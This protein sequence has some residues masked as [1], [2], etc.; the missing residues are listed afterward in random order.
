MCHLHNL[1]LLGV[2]LQMGLA[3]FW[4]ANS[5]ITDLFMSAMLWSKGEAQGCMN[6]NPGSP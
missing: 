3:A 6:E 5:C 4:E 1:I 2:D